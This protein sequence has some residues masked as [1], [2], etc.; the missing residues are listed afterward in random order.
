MIG[1]T[2]W[3]DLG[4]RP[5]LYT[6][7]FRSCS[8]T[9]GLAWLAPPWVPSTIKSRWHIIVW[10]LSFCVLIDNTH[11]REISRTIGCTMTSKIWLQGKASIRKAA[12]FCRILFFTHLDCSL[13]TFLK[14]VTFRTFIYLILVNTRAEVLAGSPNN[15]SQNLF[16]ARKWMNWTTSTSRTYPLW[17]P[18]LL[19]AVG[20]PRLPA[21]SSPP[22]LR[23]SDI[24]PP[25]IISIWLEQR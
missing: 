6:D 1:L 2:E 8:D 16:R 18:H 9:E 22:I 19:K 3:L 21:F 7:F 11:P 17:N 10:T 24:L 13:L 4:D 20:P 5:L 14:F 25:H 15:V 12:F 23:S